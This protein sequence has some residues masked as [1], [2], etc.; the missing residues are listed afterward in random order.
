ML[1]LL[2]ADSLITG[3]RRA[4]PLR[5]FPIFWEW[6]YH[7]GAADRVKIPQEQYDEVVVG[8]GDIVN[9]LKQQDVK[10]A[11]LL[12]E[13]VDPAL[14]SIVTANGYAPD[15]NEDEVEQVGRDPFL[16]AYA[17]AARAIRTVVSFETPAPAKLRANRKVPDV[18]AGFGIPCCT[19]FDLIN[20]LDFTTD[21]RP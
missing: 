16:I 19:L 4:Y 12:R 3:D 1:Y 13:S 17:L 5:R 15:L 8:R 18:C 14:L 11:L 9:W 2:D 6:L 10:D 7:M 20:D 21:W